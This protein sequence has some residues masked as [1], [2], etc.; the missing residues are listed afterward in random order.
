[1]VYVLSRSRPSSHSSGLGGA[2]PACSTPGRTRSRL[3]F[4][5]WKV[6]LQVILVSKIYGW[7]AALTFKKPPGTFNGLVVS[8]NRK[9][10]IVES[11]DAKIEAHHF[12]SAVDRWQMTLI[13]GGGGLAVAYT[14]LSHLKGLSSLH[15]SPV[16]ITEY[17]RHNWV[18]I[19]ES[20]LLPS[21]VRASAGRCSARRTNR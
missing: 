5:S 3:C 20:R 4:A 10:K 17:W 7:S 19:D 2:A 18:H 13:S 12:W 8:D 1:M 9:K 6:L 16:T 21:R 15:Y 11:G 14:C